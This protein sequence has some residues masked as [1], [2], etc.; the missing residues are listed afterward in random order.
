MSAALP[1]VAYAKSPEQER[2]V[3][4]FEGKL[5]G[6]YNLAFL[7]GVEYLGGKQLRSDIEKELGHPQYRP[8]EWSSARDMVIIFDRAVRAGVSVERVGELVFP[9]YKRANPTLFE[10]KTVVNGFELLE[11]AYREDTTYG[12]VSPGHEVKPGLVRLFRKNSPLP[13]QYFAGVL[14][15][16]L[17]VFGV[18]GSV[19]EVACQWE[20]A[21]SC[22]FEAR[23]NS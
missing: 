20:G 6:R 23:W 1:G 4:G 14:K 13:C 22:T 12:G 17:H 10:G 11:R 15:G 18:Q 21:P 3:Q 19:Q 8:D 9:A 7:V 16:V 5:K 2:F